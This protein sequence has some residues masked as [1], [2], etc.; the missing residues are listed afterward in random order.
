MSGDGF[1]VIEILVAVSILCVFVMAA[2]AFYAHI[3]LRAAMESENT[4]AMDRALFMQ[5]ILRNFASKKPAHPPEGE[6]EL[7]VDGKRQK[8][9]DLKDMIIDGRLDVPSFVQREGVKGVMLHV[10]HSFSSKDF[11][12]RWYWPDNLN[13]HPPINSLLVTKRSENMYLKPAYTGKFKSATPDALGLEPEDASRKKK[14]EVWN[15]GAYFKLTQKNFI[16]LNEMHKNG[17]VSRIYLVPKWASANKKE[18]TIR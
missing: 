14:H 17:E 10:L 8:A 18:T 12:L 16:K 11:I 1:T 7:V 3:S 13:Q 9:R 6:L 4:E 5:N 15:D 2:V